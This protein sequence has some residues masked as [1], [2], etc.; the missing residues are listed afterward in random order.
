MRNPQ[1]TPPASVLPLPELVPSLREVAAA[2]RRVKRATEPGPG[3]RIGICDAGGELV[4]G[5]RFASFN[6]VQRFSLAMADLGY[7]DVIAEDA[8]Q[9]HGFHVLFVRRAPAP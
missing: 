8:E 6:Q 5:T 7:G 9:A 4:A 3:Y 2:L 1:P